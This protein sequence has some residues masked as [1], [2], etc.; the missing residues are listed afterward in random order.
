VLDTELPL[1]GASA[2]ELAPLA[3][4]FGEQL[5]RLLDAVAGRDLSAQAARDLLCD[6]DFMP[7]GSTCSDQLVFDGEDWELHYGLEVG[8]DLPLFP[9]GHDRLALELVGE[10]DGIDVQVDAGDWSGSTGG[11]TLAFNLG[12]K[13]S[14]DAEL[15]AQLDAHEAAG[16]PQ[17]DDPTI[18]DYTLAAGDLCRGLA[19]H[20]GVSRDD[21]RAANDVDLAG[22]AALVSTGTSVDLPDETSRTLDAADVCTATARVHNRTAEA[23]HALNGFADDGACATAVEGRTASTAFHWDPEPPDVRLGHRIFIDTTSAPFVSLSLD[24]EGEGVG[25]D[26]RLG[27]LDQEQRKL[28]I[29]GAAEFKNHSGDV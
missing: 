21:L 18:R 16:A 4:G 24:L 17:P 12:V 19:R 1:V 27:F 29:L 15:K 14:P 7:A 10:L 5:D 22:C 26:V 20:L 28:N 3:A 25:A 13:L 23:F 6:L 2:G 8:F 9:D 11:A